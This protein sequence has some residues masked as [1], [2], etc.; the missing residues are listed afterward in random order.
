[1]KRLYAKLAQDHLSQY[2]Q[3]LFLVGPRQVGKTT[4]ANLLLKNAHGLYLNWDN[5][6]DRLLF[7]GAYEKIIEKLGP[8]KLGQTKPLIVLDEIHKYKHWKNHLKGFYD[9]YKDN[10][11]IVVTGSAKLDIYHKGGDSL[12]GRYFPYT[13][14]P[15]SLRECIDPTLIREDLIR[16][17]CIDPENIYDDLFQYGGFPDVMRQVKWPT[18]R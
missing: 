9:T 1:M 18:K 17:P 16:L 4:A 13:V 2:N 6:D 10:V 5:P 8:K 15:L 11:N 12:M 7:L 3:M 14:H